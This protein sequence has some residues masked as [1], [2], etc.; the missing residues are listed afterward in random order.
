[1]SKWKLTLKR[2]AI[3]VSGLLAAVSALGAPKKW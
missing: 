2:A 1:M 3:T